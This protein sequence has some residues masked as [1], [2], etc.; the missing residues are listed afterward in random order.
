MVSKEKH[1]ANDACMLIAS[2]TICNKV[3]TPFAL[4]SV[5]L[6]NVEILSS[7]NL[8]KLFPEPSA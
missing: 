1:C 3:Q 5:V 4:L 6:H 8:R 7:Y 2:K